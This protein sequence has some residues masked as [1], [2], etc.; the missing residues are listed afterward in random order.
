[1]QGKRQYFPDTIHPNEEGQQL[2][3]EIVFQSVFGKRKK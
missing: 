1:M 2:I 3:A